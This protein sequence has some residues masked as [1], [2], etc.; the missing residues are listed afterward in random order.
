MASQ[1][2][3]PSPSPCS[4]FPGR[5]LSASDVRPNNR[6][7]FQSTSMTA[8]YSHKVADERGDKIVDVFICKMGKKVKPYGIEIV[9]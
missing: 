8:L 6:T 3:Q 4:A 7:P 1:N 2:P 5:R 9:I